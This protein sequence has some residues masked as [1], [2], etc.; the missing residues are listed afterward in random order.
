MGR[1]ARGQHIQDDDINKLKQLG[2]PFLVRVQ[3]RDPTG[4]LTN[5]AFWENITLE[6]LAGPFENV[7]WEYAGGGEFL[8]SV[9]SPDDRVRP[10][11][12]FTVTVP[13][14]PKIPDR[15]QTGQHATGGALPTIPGVP[16]FGPMG[17]GGPPPAGGPGYTPFPAYP[18]AAAGAWSPWLMTNP[19]WNQQ[20][21]HQNEGNTWAQMAVFE[22]QRNSSAARDREQRT[23]EWEE[24]ERRERTRREQERQDRMTD[25][26]FLKMMGIAPTRAEEAP[27]VDPQLESLKSLVEALKADLAH[28]K[29]S[30]AR[31]AAD[32][33]HREDVERL[34]REGEERQK[35]LEARLEKLVEATTAA[36]AVPVTDPL[37]AERLR[38]EELRRV[39]EQKRADEA[40]RWEEQ[41]RL[42][43]LRREQDR[44]EAEERRTTEDRRR[45]EDRTRREAEAEL[46]RQEMEMRRSM[47]ADKRSTDE[48]VMTMM[49]QAMKPPDQ[50]AALAALGGIFNSSLQGQAAGSQQMMTVLGEAFKGAGKAGELPEWM[51]TIL[52]KSLDK[53]DHMERL[54]EATGRLMS[55]AFGAMGQS[56]QQMSQMNEG[57]PWVRIAET[58]FREVGGIGEALLGSRVEGGEGEMLPPPEQPLANLPPAPEP[59]RAAGT[60]RTEEV[61]VEE[62]E[63][64][65][66]VEPE[67]VEGSEVATPEVILKSRIADLRSAIETGIRP[68]VAA[69][70]LVELAVD[71]DTFSGPLPNPLD[72]MAHDPDGVVQELFGEWILQFGDSGKAYL[73]DMKAWVRREMAAVA[74]EGG[75]D[76]E[77]EE[78]EGEDE[79]VAIEVKPEVAVVEPV[80]AESAVEEGKVVVDAVAEQPAVTLEAV[81]VPVEDQ[82]AA[83]NGSKAP[84]PAH[85]GR[86]PKAGKG[87][88]PPDAL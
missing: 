62:P 39:E 28:A 25:P 56:L 13:G 27:K 26:F 40:K 43:E 15:F 41:K 16:G 46:R 52:A 8:I 37:A 23:M 7:L 71:E 88:A 49:M 61:E 74:V 81:P 83:T 44:K 6:D 67:E 75:E 17:V 2:G 32:A 21:H 47:E 42:D 4:R 80:A 11:H 10:K 77:E 73:V 54:T 33:R 69:R 55:I 48:R 57:N 60:V 38:I 31:E 30:S 68:A 79:A 82:P 14:E 22:T 76:E 63:E 64:V 12:T 72:K 66:E 86:P 65:E 84:P 85:R 18:Q 59:R 34:R 45:E 70:A 9:L 87:V 51:G 35:A 36:K 53:S 19:W 78:G 50:T 3:R 24:H 20:Q 58:F 5:L 29:D 1:G